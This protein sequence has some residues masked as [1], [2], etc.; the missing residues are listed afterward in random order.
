MT[1]DVTET[2]ETLRW[3]D[4]LRGGVANQNST[5]QKFAAAARELIT[6]PD[7][8][9]LL[10]TAESLLRHIAASESDGEAREAA[11]LIWRIMEKLGA[12]P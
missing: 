11:A 6:A 12:T 7:R 5:A 8:D 3:L 10:I 1:S 9:D 2:E 4:E